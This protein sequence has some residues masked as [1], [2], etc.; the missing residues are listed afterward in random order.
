MSRGTCGCWILAA[1]KKKREGGK[2]GGK[3]GSGR[4]AGNGKRA[5]GRREQAWVVRWWVMSGPITAKVFHTDN[6]P[7]TEAF[8]HSRWLASVAPR[9]P[10]SAKCVNLEI[11][12]N[13]PHPRGRAWVASPNLSLLLLSRCSLTRGLSFSFVR[14]LTRVAAAPLPSSGFHFLA[15]VH[16]ERPIFSCVRSIVHATVYYVCAQYH[17]LYCF[18]CGVH[19]HR[20]DA[21]S[22][23]AVLPVSQ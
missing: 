13:I 15:R 3:A 6:T 11:S 1:K 20:I 16:F 9:E 8:T 4:E 14:G 10:N 19:Q 17:C 5:P 18:H 23:S 2:I 22:N 12:L 7:P 21:A